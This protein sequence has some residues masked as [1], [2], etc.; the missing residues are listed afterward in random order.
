[1][2]RIGYERTAD[3]TIEDTIPLEASTLACFV[4]SDTWPEASKPANVYMGNKRPRHQLAPKDTP[5]F[6][7]MIEVHTTVEFWKPYV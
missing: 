1:M 5:G 6:S 3:D 4:S 2:M 7:F